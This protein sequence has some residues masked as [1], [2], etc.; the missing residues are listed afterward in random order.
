[1]K[2]LIC[3]FVGL[4]LILAAGRTLFAYTVPED[5]SRAKYFYVF[6]PE[7]DPDMGAEEGTV[8][9]YID[10]PQNAEGDVVLGIYDPDTGGALD[11]TE[12][13]RDVRWDTTTEFAVYGRNE[14]LLGKEKFSETKEYDRKYYYF[15]PYA[16]D[17]GEKVGNNYRFKLAV[18][19]LTGD[20]ENLFNV[21]IWPAV[22]EAFS[23]KFCVRL[24]SQERAKMYFYPEVPA[25]VDRIVFGNY[26]MDPHGGHGILYDRELNRWHKIKD[27]ATASW[28][29]TIV[30]LAFT[31]RTKRLT[32]TITKETQRNA[33]MGMRVKDSDGNLLPIY[34]QEG[35][36]VPVMRVKKEP[37]VMPAKP[38]EVPK[39]NNK[40]T[41]DA[42]KSYDPQNRN[43]VYLWDF[44]DGATSTEPVT[45]HI[46]EKPGTYTVK[47][48]VRNDSN[49]ECDTSESI[50]TIRINS[51]PMVAFVASSDK[52]CPGQE[53]NFDASATT[54]DTPGKLTYKWDFGDGT[55]AEG[56]RV[57]KVYTKSGVYRVVLTV[58]DNEGTLCSVTTK[59]IVMTVNTP[60]IADAGKDID[61]CI[62]A[63]EDYRVQFSAAKAKSSDDEK[64][65]YRW[66]FGDGTTAEG[67]GITHVYKK[68]GDY[69][70]K[71]T[72]SDGLGLACSIANDTVNV[73]LNKQP[74]AVAGPDVVACVGDTVSFDASRSYTE[75]KANL[76]YVWDFG[77]GTT[78]E[79][80]SVNHVYK[81]GGKFEGMLTVDDGKGKRCSAAIDKFVADVNT[82]PVAQL[83]DIRAVCVN[84][85]VNFDAS[86]S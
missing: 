43:L 60:P 26:D 66:D 28:A 6:G 63:K 80:K 57:N 74:I 41:F 65:T 19:T 44:G 30:H 67:M 2:K 40:F 25:S 62:P 18:R 5:D 22:S 29:E 14:E 4:V 10:V 7:G 33:N 69:I 20:D 78:L 81:K 21:M 56:V 24:L 70:V 77:D 75:E 46:Y 48:T 82:K 23:Y 38:L 12:T 34:F 45:T 54:D 3:F 42:T 50:E 72:V 59:S 73:S 76:K 31:D 64:I 1:M 51:A 8:V 15:G 83:A 32:Y 16:K 55:T 86:G 61:M 79:G 36:P 85:E 17:K 37:I 47:L 39:C 68:G 49:L 9:L 52:A 27:S 71:L 35:K 11:S 13:V 53:I 84:T 58:D